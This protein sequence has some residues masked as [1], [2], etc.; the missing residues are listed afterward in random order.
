[1]YVH[2]NKSNV[3][4]DVEILAGNTSVFPCQP[5]MVHTLTPTHTYI[6]TYIYICFIYMYKYVYIYIYIYAIYVAY[7]RLCKTN[8]I[9]VRN[10]IVF[11]YLI[12]YSNTFCFW[13]INILLLAYMYLY[14]HMQISHIHTIHTHTYIYIYI[15]IYIFSSVCQ[16]MYRV[17]FKYSFTRYIID[18]YLCANVH[19]VCLYKKC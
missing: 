1:M 10:K 18:L 3:Y 4:R 8:E 7:I 16:C 17:I 5:Y 2:I 19:I 13:L 15:Y 9:F 11:S 14:S 6:Y 12:I